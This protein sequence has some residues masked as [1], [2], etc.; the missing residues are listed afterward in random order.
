MF[1]YLNIV[2]T[3]LV[4]SEDVEHPTLNNQHS[5]MKWMLRIIPSITSKQAEEVVNRA[6]QVYTTRKDP[7]STQDD[8]FLG[9]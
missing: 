6:M 7:S 2:Q 4:S 1:L 3:E 5:M 8:P 9:V